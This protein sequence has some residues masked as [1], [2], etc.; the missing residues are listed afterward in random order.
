MREKKRNYNNCG[1][2]KYADAFTAFLCMK[3]AF[4]L[5]L[6]TVDRVHALVNRP[7]LPFHLRPKPKSPSQRNG[8]RLPRLSDLSLS[9]AYR[10]MGQRHGRP[11]DAPILPMPSSRV[12]GQPTTSFPG[13]DPGSCGIVVLAMAPNRP[14]CRAEPRGP[15]QAQLRR[16]L[17]PRRHAQARSFLG[18]ALRSGGRWPDFEYRGVP[19]SGAPPR[20]VRGQ[21]RLAAQRAAG[22]MAHR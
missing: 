19:E 4:I 1:G 16:L 17:S 6:P 14:R 10:Y 11:S 20:V 9:R 7:Q 3:F 2:T 18:R 22:K 12:P 21:G 5:R 15:G 8:S 13:D